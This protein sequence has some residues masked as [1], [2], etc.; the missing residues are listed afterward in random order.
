[1]YIYIYIYINVHMYI[2]IH[3]CMY[4]YICIY[5][6]THIYIYIYT[7]IY[8]YAYVWIYI[9]IH[10]YIFLWVCLCAH[11]RVFTCNLITWYSEFAL[12]SS[13]AP[14]KF[15]A[16]PGTLCVELENIIT[17]RWQDSGISTEYVLNGTCVQHAC[18]LCL[19]GTA[20]VNYSQT[21]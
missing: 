17:A 21:L 7:Y 19:P 2:Y 20:A 10:L 13:C 1:M 6:H 9:H 14:G 5:I 12:C 18:P 8:V 3:I 11:F 4:T 16:R 15:G